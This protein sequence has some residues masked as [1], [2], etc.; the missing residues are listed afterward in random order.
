MALF[1]LLCLQMV[2]KG[3]SPISTLSLQNTIQTIHSVH[4][5]YSKLSQEGF[6]YLRLLI[7]KSALP[8]VKGVRLGKAQIVNFKFELAKDKVAGGF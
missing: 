4:R 6:R 8:I 3:I 5:N 7:S 1:L 2:W